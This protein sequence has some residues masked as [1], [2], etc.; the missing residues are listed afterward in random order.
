MMLVDSKAL[1]K[2]AAQLR[3]QGKAVAELRNG[4]PV[5]PEQLDTA[6]RILREA[7][8]SVITS[9]SGPVE[10]TLNKPQERPGYIE[11]TRQKN[12]EVLVF[13]VGILG[14]TYFIDRKGEVIDP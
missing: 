5:S 13:D 7:E 14:D 10:V 6:A 9:A 4:V 3:E 2:G 12:P 8:P 1:E 11:E